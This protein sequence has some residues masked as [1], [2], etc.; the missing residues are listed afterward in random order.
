MGLLYQWD[1][2]RPGALRKSRLRTENSA[3]PQDTSAPALRFLTQRPREDGCGAVTVQMLTGKAD[4]DIAPLFGWQADELRRTDWTNLRRVLSALDWQ[5]GDIAPVSGW[6]EINDLAIVHVR[7]D[8]F[9]LYDGQNGLFYDPWEWQ[10]PQQT[11][12]RVPM[13]F[14]KVTPLRA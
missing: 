10:G 1:I 3:M 5:L 9:M 12:S 13:T 8:H 2:G 14:A 11:S 7:D 4:E 6:D